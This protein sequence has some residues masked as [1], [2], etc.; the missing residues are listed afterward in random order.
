MIFKYA[1]QVIELYGHAGISY[2]T[3]EVQPTMVDR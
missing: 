1:V 3:G 2:K